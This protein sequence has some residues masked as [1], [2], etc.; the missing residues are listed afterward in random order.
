MDP[1]YLTLETLDIG[2][3]LGFTWEV[4]VSAFFYVLGVC[5]FWVVC[6]AGGI[7][8]VG[9]GGTHFQGVTLVGVRCKGVRHASRVRIRTDNVWAIRKNAPSRMSS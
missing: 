4:P 5:V 3:D 9:D 2:T 7:L 8:L 1:R 6:G